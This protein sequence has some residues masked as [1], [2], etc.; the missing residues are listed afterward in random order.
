MAYEF[1]LNKQTEKKYEL[2]IYHAKSTVRLVV[3]KP[4]IQEGVLK[5]TKISKIAFDSQFYEACEPQ[6]FIAVGQYTLTEYRGKVY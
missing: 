4:N 3:I 1:N 6:E 2:A 5:A